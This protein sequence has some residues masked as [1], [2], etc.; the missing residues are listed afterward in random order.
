[1]NTQGVCT[2]MVNS[3]IS[4]QPSSMRLHN[5]NLHWH[6]SQPGSLKYFTNKAEVILT[7]FRRVEMEQMA[8]HPNGKLS[9]GGH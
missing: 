7:Q 2:H 8:S 5:N 4:T 3:H 1:M 6:N 9:Q